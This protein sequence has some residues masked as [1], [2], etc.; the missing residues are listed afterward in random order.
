MARARAL[1][2]EPEVGDADR[3][4]RP[5]GSRAWMRDQQLRSWNQRFAELAG[6]AFGA[7]TP[8]EDLFRRQAAAGLFGDAAEAEQ[9]IATRLTLLPS[10]ARSAEPL[11]QTGP[12][13]E[14]LRLVVRGVC[15]GGHLLVLARVDISPGSGR[16]RTP[17]GPRQRRKRR[18][19]NAAFLGTGSFGELAG[20]S[21]GIRTHDPQS[22]RLMRY[23]TALRSDRAER[24]P[25]GRCPGQSS[26]PGRRP[27][28]RTGI[29]PGELASAEA[30]SPPER[31]STGDGSAADACG[32][33]D[34]CQIQLC[35]RP[36]RGQ[37]PRRSGAPAWRG[38]TIPAPAG[39]N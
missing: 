34:G 28:N 1:L 26:S 3:Q 16:C 13:G 29:R 19:G 30:W 5:T 17:A 21:G 22:P 36:Q 35:H 31:K 9:A 6:V 10:A 12:D 39:L 8:V 23:Q 33:Q 18:N 4:R 15:D 7:D 25:A 2:T 38:F 24:L 14:P 32:V 20:R 37:P 11:T 27:G